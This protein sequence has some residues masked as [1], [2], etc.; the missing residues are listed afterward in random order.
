[1]HALSAG[2]EH[3]CDLVRLEERADARDAHVRSELAAAARM[4]IQWER[5][6]KRRSISW[7]PSDAA[8]AKVNDIYKKVIYLKAERL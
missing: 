8:V 2:L 5:I 4:R 6:R 1:M 3:A 7:D